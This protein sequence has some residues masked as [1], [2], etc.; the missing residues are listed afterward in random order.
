MFQSFDTPSDP[1]KGAFRLSKLRAEMKDEALDGFLVPRADVHQGEYVIA[2]DARLAWLTGFTGSAGFA[3]V[4][5]HTAGVFIDG[6]YRL[7][8]LDQVDLGVF[9][10][11]HWPEVS[12]GAWLA[13]TV[14]E[15]RI[16]YDPWLHTLE[17]IERTQAALEGVPVDLV[18]CDNLVDR[19]W[20]DD[21]PAAP[22]DL[23]VPYPEALAGVSAADKRS[24]LAQDLH[25]AGQRAAVLTQ[26]DAIAWLLNVR[27]SDL[28]QTPVAQAFAI[29]HDDGQVDLLIDPV[30]VDDALRAHLGNGVRLDV[31]DNLLSLLAALRGD[32][33][34]IRLDKSTAPV[35]IAQHLEA[36]GI[37]IDWDRD[38]T[39]LPKACKSETELQATT[40]A[41]LRDGG[42][43][44]EFLCWLDAQRGRS[45][46]T[47]IEVVQKLEACRRATGELQNISFDTICGSGPNGA[48]VHY[49]VTEATNR[50]IGQDDILLVD[51]GGQYLD[52]TT[53]ITRTVAMGVPPAGAVFANTLV[54]KGMIAI[55]RLRFPKGLAGRDID[56]LARAALWAE[57]LDYDHGTGHGVGVYLGVHEGPQRISKV[58]DVPLQ[59]GMILSNEPGYYKTGA[60]GI[61][62]ENLIVVEEAPALPR[63]DARDMLRFR[64][65][66][67]APLDRRLIDAEMLTPVE[68]AWVDAY[69]T[70]VL[71]CIGPLVSAD[72]RAWL[73]SACAAL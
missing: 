42:A 5:D 64:T 11:V 37:D 68:R 66:T 51:S 23:M 13:E 24:K 30:K 22:D 28:G 39:A 56:A 14:S 6:R 2:R 33:V 29:L 27:G 8:V 57:G 20:Q 26:P 71:E 34:T 36:E 52:G 21:R 70:Q 62:I 16:G 54:L 72:A 1:A 45:D 46:L 63:G 48:I 10:P 9:T 43:V 69:N 17:E 12:L 49:R 59:A 31:P 65:L 19:I 47:E 3:C 35:A 7:Q 73:R 53:D 58:S 61:R 4:L 44:V 40:A 18:P 41:H 38:P 67:F 55:S 50:T 25:A 60:F 15:G 32:G